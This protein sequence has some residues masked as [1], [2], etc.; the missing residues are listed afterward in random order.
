MHNFDWFDFV[1]ICSK[2]HTFFKI[3]WLLIATSDFV[4]LIR[5]N[6]GFFGKSFLWSYII[7]KACLPDNELI[8]LLIPSRVIIS[9]TSILILLISNAGIFLYCFMTLL[10]IFILY[11][12]GL[13]VFLVLSSLTKFFFVLF[14]PST[15]AAKVF[16]K[17]LIFFMK[18]ILSNMPIILLLNSASS[19][20]GVGVSSAFK[21]EPI[22]TGIT[23]GIFL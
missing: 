12:F 11:N 21:S 9:L 5:Q 19:S 8:L 20:M 4:E 13:I 15:Y 1:A 2:S 7:R 6:E 16:W 18:T 14:N 17:L 23:V 10:V 22:F 3:F